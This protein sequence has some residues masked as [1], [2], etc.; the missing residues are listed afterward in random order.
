MSLARSTWTSSSCRPRTTG[1]SA[2]ASN[3][4][5]STS[6]LRRASRDQQDRVGPLLIGMSAICGS[7]CGAAGQ[8]ALAQPAKLARLAQRVAEQHE[9]RG[10]RSAGLVG[11]ALAQL[12]ELEGA[13]PE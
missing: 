9:G 7:T 6:S 8:T 10:A 3:R 2:A 11:A 12:D 13:R 4:V 1:T 5:S